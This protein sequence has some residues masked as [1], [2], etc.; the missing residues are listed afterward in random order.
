MANSQVSNERE[1]GL[2]WDVI[3]TFVW[4]KKQ[5]NPVRRTL[6]Q[7]EIW[8]LDL[9]NTKVECFPIERDAEQNYCEYS[10]RKDSGTVLVCF[11]APSQHLPL[12][13]NIFHAEEWTTIVMTSKA[14]YLNTVVTAGLSVLMTSSMQYIVTI[15]SVA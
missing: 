10:T 8:T 15:V 5:H 4:E 12:E 3:L 11:K 14:L 7:T 1:R 6:F 13:K 9:S 2:I